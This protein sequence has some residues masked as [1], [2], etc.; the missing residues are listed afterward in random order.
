MQLKTH[1]L[2]N[3]AEMSE[4]RYLLHA[5]YH[6]LYSRFNKNGHQLLA[7]L[8]DIY[9]LAACAFVEVVQTVI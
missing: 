6:V 4:G 3:Y 5:S 9:A 1:T 7:R 2:H 8:L